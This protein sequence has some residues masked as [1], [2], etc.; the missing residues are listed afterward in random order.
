[1]VVANDADDI[2]TLCLPSH[3]MQWTNEE[4][5]GKQDGISD[6]ENCSFKSYS[7]E[8]EL[9]QGFIE[10]V[11]SLDPDIIMGFEVQKDSIGYL[12]D[13]ANVLEIN[14]LR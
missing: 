7:G 4:H 6:I 5:E 1:M 10:S 13:R 3:V 11:I 12:V 14:L 2:Q 8:K 9:L